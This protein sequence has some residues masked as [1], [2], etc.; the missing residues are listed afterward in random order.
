MFLPL[1]NNQV[2]LGISFILLAAVL[3][4]TLRTSKR[5]PYPLPPGPPGEPILGHFR[6]I[7]AVGPEHKYI[8]WSKQYGE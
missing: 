8:E 4:R 3:V 2:L 5:V 6:V 7:P 1:N